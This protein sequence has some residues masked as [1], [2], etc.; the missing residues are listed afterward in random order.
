[1]I[2]NILDR[3]LKFESVVFLYTEASCYSEDFME[4]FR[5]KDSSETSKR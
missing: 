1:M 4:C 5:Y 2:H 3:F